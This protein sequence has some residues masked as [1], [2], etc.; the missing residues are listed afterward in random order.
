MENIIMN[1]D[2]TTDRRDLYHIDATFF[3]LVELLVVIGVIAILASLLLPALNQARN[4][5]KA[6]SCVSNE[7][8]LGLAF[9]TY[10]NDFNGF[11]LFRWSP[12]AGNWLRAYA[13]HTY[14][15]VHYVRDYIDPKIAVCP[16]APPYSYDEASNG[17]NA[18]L[19]TYAVNI[20]TEYLKPIMSEWKDDGDPKYVCVRLDQMPKAEKAAG[21]RIPVL[22]ETRTDTD[23][24]Q[25]SYLNRRSATYLINLL[26]NARVNILLA[27]G[28]VESF[29]QKSVKQQLNFERGGIVNGRYIPQA[30]W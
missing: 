19:Y 5:A 8:Q 28:H 13:S 7:K 30:S 12:Y 16:T 23:P 17:N 29:D 10:A 27:D 1:N 18:L 20:D 4:R 3:T 15:N 25:I 2:E 11:V 21:Y 26:H 9:A 6:I 24:H 22:G 14:S